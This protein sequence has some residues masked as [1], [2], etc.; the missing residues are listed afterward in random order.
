MGAPFGAVAERYRARAHPSDESWAETPGTLAKAIYPKTIQTPALSLIDQVIMDAFATP[1]SRTIISMPPQEGKSERVTK[2]GTLWGLKHHPS[3]R[4]AIVS[5]AQP[6]A[7]GFSRDIR[8]WIVSND[9]TEGSLDLGLRIARDNG[10]AR[11][12]SLAGKGRRGG[13][14]AVG[15]EGGLTGRPVD[16]LMIDDP[17]KDAEQADSLYYRE[18][19]HNWWRGVGATRLA[20]GAPVVLIMTR[21]HED[22]LAGR[23][24]AGEDGSRWRVVNIPALADHDPE[25]GQMDPLGR[26]PGVWMESARTDE[27]TGLQRTVEQWESIRLQ[28]GTRAFTAMYQGRPSPESGNVWRR[29]WWRRYETLLWRV[30]EAGAYH[31]DC[32]EMILS[33]DMAFK[34]TKSSDWV[35]GMVLARKGAEVF[36]LDVV[37]KRLSFTDTLVAFEAQVRAWPQAVAKIVEEKA[38]GAAVIDSLRKKIP[39]LIP[40]NPTESKFSRATA[41]SP[42]VEAG[43][44]LLPSREVALFDVEALIDEA[45]AFPNGTHDDQV[46][47]LSQGLKRLLLVMGSGAAFLQAMKER[48]AAEGRE[49][50]S[51]AR[52]WRERAAAAREQRKGGTGGEA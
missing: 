1:D 26:E 40:E 18:R 37:R 44:V 4:F 25:K 51:S 21:W 46:D 10:A 24:Q 36:V 14:V 2:T 9:G 31:V 50:P 34:D 28:S 12:W 19:A 5:Y 43:N 52:N 8:N 22:D 42:F 48:L 45:A 39:G 17:F 15:L 20:P 30:D 49:V 6:L 33:W 13:V 41:V 29:Q 38:N 35:V 47:A 23:L 16:A 32:D 27:R 3:W 11:R 7:E